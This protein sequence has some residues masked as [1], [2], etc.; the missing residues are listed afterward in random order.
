M[1]VTS[2]LCDSVTCVVTLTDV[3][4]Y[5]KDDKAR[6]SSLGAGLYA[7]GEWSNVH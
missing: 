6:T 5:T 2:K 1:S 3:A 7:D 4:N